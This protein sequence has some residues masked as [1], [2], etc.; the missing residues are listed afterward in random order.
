MPLRREIF[1]WISIPSTD[2]WS[3]PRQQT[4]PRELE[5]ICC[6]AMHKNPKNRYRNVSAMIDELQNYLDGYP[7]RAYSPSPFY[8]LGKWFSRHPLIPVTVL[9]LGLGVG[10]FRIYTSV[11]ENAEM[12]SRFRQA[13]YNADRAAIQATA[14]RSSYRKLKHDYNLSYNERFNLYRNVHKMAALMSNSNAV[15]LTALAQLPRSFDDDHSPRLMLAREIFRRSI[16]LYRELGDNAQLQEAVENYRRRW[17][18]LFL[19][20]LRNDPELLKQITQAESHRGTLKVQLPENWEMEI[21]TPAGKV[22]DIRRDKTAG[23]QLSEQDCIAA[24]SSRNGKF[25]FPVKIHSGKTTVLSPG[26]PNYIPD[27]LCY[28]GSG[29]IPVQDL[30]HARPG[31]D[32]PPFMISKYE[33][34]VG[35]YLKFWKSLPPEKREKFLPMTSISTGG[36]LQGIWDKNGK[37][38][39]PYHLNKPVTGISREGAAAYCAWLGRKMRKKVTL[40]SAAQWQ[41][42]AFRFPESASGGIFYSENTAKLFPAGAPVTIQQQDISAFGVVNARG[43]VRELLSNLRGKTTQVTGGSFLTPENAVD[44]QQIQFTISGDNDI[45]FRYVV[46][47]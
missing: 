12:Q 20:V 40:P 22:L 43:N 35:D 4:V 38:R 27:N 13:Q 42:A 21:L 41:K 44:R 1:P 6:K 34:S 18:T 7:V 14:A 46:E 29:E 5:A 17:G 47:L 24:F 10:G 45:G 32:I 16:M 19:E 11:Q 37:L 36:K 33:V 26:Y 15:A 2:I 25:F 9:A 28:I 39:S 30:V 23:L 3:A 31:G 8:R